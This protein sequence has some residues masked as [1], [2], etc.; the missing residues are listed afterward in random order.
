MI[1]LEWLTFGIV[2]ICLLT[3]P[4]GLGLFLKLSDMKG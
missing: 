4:V 2:L 1:E 3:F